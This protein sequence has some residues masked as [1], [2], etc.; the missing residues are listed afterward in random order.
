MSESLRAGV[1]GVGSLGRYHAQKYAAHAGAELVGV[2]DP[3]S[4]RAADVAGEIGCRSYG[5]LNALLAEVDAVT[6]AAPTEVHR[7]LGVAALEAGVHVLMEKPLAAT[8]EEADA[9]LEAADRSGRVL[10]VGHLLRF[11]PGVRRIAEHGWDRQPPRY[12]EASR[13]N[14]FQPRSLD[15]DVILD[16]MVH[17]LD[18][19]LNWVQAPV[20][21]VRAIGI[22]V[23]T[24]KVDMA[25][26][27]IAFANG[28]VA[29]VTASRVARKQ[30]REVRMFQPH[31]YVSV[32]F[33][34][35][36]MGVYELDDGAA[37]G[38]VPGARGTQEALEARDLLAEEVAMFLAAC[39]GRISDGV[40]G[41]E[42]RAALDLGLRVRT[43]IDDHF[44]RYGIPADLEEESF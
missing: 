33:V 17:D 25:N 2:F 10:Q 35:S 39:R 6:V 20:A 32:D 23:V 4:D 26:A 43:A 1:V 37:E 9:L 30:V 19:I 41:I 38:P 16:L 22:P 8:L 13:L 11:H 15:I 12:L 27:R 42:G 28:A 7:E 31:R 24:E 14:T 44:Q 21:E 3:D 29:N 34:D 5:D 36:A 18:L 40:S